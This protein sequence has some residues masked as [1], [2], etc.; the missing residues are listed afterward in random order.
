MRTLRRRATPAVS[1]TPHTAG[2]PDAL[3]DPDADGL[4]VVHA[5][6]WTGGSALATRSASTL[7]WAALLCGPAAALWLLLGGTGGGA[8][9][10]AAP[11]PPPPADRSGQRAAVQAFAQDVVV[12]W[13]TS[14]VGEEQRLAE[15]MQ[16]SALTLPRRP[17]TVTDPATAGIEPVGGG[18]WSVTVAATVTDP[19]AAPL[20]EAQRLDLTQDDAGAA[21]PDVLPLP[22]GDDELPVPQRRHFHLAVREADGALLAVGQPSPV[23]GPPVAQQVRLGYRYRA[24]VDSAPAAA[25][26]QFL[27]ALLTG[28][29][30][31]TRYTTPGTVI[32]PVDPPPY[33]D[34]EVREVRSDTDLTD[35]PESPADGDALRVL[36][37]AV[38]GTADPAAQIS[39]EYP[40]SLLARA[41]RWEVAA[42]DP[43]PALASATVDGPSPTAPP[44]RSSPSPSPSPSPSS[45]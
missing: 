37:T 25:A 16:T 5:S 27:A 2:V 12:S 28:T 23:A 42:V 41:G 24:P 29:G 36:V 1:A 19:P 6:R 39:L 32:P 20:T 3:D 45:R 22:S 18:L 8:S 43:A 40:L 17:W 11:A 4:P 15:V 21:P 13:L 26:Q 9:T 10:A 7:L 35:L 44:A 30:D 31:L 34:V 33:A 14:P 38:A